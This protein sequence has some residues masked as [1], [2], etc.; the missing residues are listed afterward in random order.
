MPASIIPSFEI[1]DQ[2]EI[3]RFDKMPD[4]LKRALV[5]RLTP[6]QQQML[7]RVI[8]VAPRRTGKLISEIKGFV[9]VG[10]DWVRAR[11][12]V[13]IDKS[14]GSGPRGNFDAGK[15]GSLEYGARTVAHVRAFRRKRGETVNTYQR[16][17]NIAARRFL[18]GPFAATSAQAT[19]A[20]TA[21][22]GDTTK[23]F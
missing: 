18:R 10:P 4:A 5:A 9:D 12:R 7:A 2:R 3:A 16:R 11:V 14:A 19:A 21:A 17:V 22:I 23:G 20:I 1:N 8:A 13:V 6:V 15:A